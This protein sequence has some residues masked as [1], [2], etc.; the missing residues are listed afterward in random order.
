MMAATFTYPED[1][2]RA[3]MASERML[4]LQQNATQLVDDL[5]AVI[6]E[7]I[8]REFSDAEV[9]E[10]N[11]GLVAEARRRLAAEGGADAA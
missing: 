2:V 6:H 9:L 8:R 7:Y 4:E 11:E 5:D 10:I 3:A 1:L